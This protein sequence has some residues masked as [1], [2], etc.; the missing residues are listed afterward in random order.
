MDTPLYSAEQIK[1]PPELPEI[2][3][4]YAKHI[5]KKQPVDI[6]SSSLEYFN[7]LSNQSVQAI[8]LRLSNS[9]LEAFYNKVYCF[10]MLVLCSGARI[11]VC[12]L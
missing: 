7:N 11:A 3:K 8:E 9:Q 4:N 2:L 1:I 10:F 6:L 5:I 12:Y